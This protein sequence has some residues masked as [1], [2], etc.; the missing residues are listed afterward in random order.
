MNAHNWISFCL[1]YFAVII[2]AVS[3]NFAFDG[4][5]I[6]K[7]ICYVSLGFCVFWLVVNV[8]EEIRRERNE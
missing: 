1:L 6:C 3:A 8:I 5:R 7:G 2:M 4:I